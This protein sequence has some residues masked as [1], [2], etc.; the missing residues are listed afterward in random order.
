MTSKQKKVSSLDSKASAYKNFM[1]TEG[2]N[3][4]DFIRIWEW[5]AKAKN[6]IY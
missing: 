5:F 6:G 2:D 1:K 3:V 4:A